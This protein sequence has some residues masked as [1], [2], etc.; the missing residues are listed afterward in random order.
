MHTK[1]NVIEEKSVL[2]FKPIFTSV[3]LHITRKTRKDDDDW[4]S[5][6][7]ADWHFLNL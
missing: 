6:V 3:T 7:G 4:I 1:E 5:Q 2:K